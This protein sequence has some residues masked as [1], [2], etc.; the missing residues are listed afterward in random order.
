[1]TTFRVKT[2]KVIKLDDLTHKLWYN[3]II[4]HSHTVILPFHWQLIPSTNLYS[5]FYQKCFCHEIVILLHLL[6]LCS[7][8]PWTWICVMCWQLTVCREKYDIQCTVE[9]VSSMTYSALL[10]Q[11][12][13]WLTLH[14][15][16][17]QECDIQF[18]VQPLS[19]VTN[20]A[21]LNHLAVWNTVHSWAT[22]QCDIQYAVEPL[23]NCVP[24]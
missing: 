12:A 24:W 14:T 8:K 18:K 9:T 11:S 23:S 3:T 19:Y 10:D 6:F 16:T 4:L 2:K 5:L 1:M 15:W 22:Q 7:I 21:Q 13:V 17:T 20:S